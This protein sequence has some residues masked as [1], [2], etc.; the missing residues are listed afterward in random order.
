MRDLG[1]SG[2]WRISAISASP[3]PVF[4]A[5][6]RLSSRHSCSPPSS[7]SIFWTG[8][9]CAG[10]SRAMPPRRYGRPVRI[11]GDL[12]VDLFRRQPHVSR[13]WALSSAI[14][15]GRRQAQAARHRSDRYRIPPVARF[16]RASH[17]AAGRVRSARRSC[18]CA[19][20][21]GRTNWD[22]SASP[23]KPGWKIP[24]IQH[25]LVT[26]RA[27]RNRRRGPQAE[28]SSARFRRE[29]NAGGKGA[30]LSV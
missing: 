10:R 22:G 30:A 29:E 14:P 4:C 23:G 17:S 3:G 6:R 2:S 18:W 26:R 16:V 21:D 11:E 9:R 24:P 7:R 8:T 5:G 13:G 20:A 19:T 12:K 28:I 27:C 1:G 15:P 25:F